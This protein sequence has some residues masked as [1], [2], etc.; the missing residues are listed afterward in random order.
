[1][2]RCVITENTSLRTTR[3]LPCKGGGGV[4][5]SQ[6]TLA[7]DCIISNNVAMGAG[8]GLAA[9]GGIV[10]R[11][12]ITDNDSGVAGQTTT[13]DGGGCF[14]GST[15]DCRVL[16]D[17]CQILCNRANTSHGGG[18]IMGSTS[19]LELR[20]C[21]V[22]GNTALANAGGIYAHQG[23]LELDNCTITD[24]HVEDSTS[25][26]AAGGFYSGYTNH[27]RN[28][29][30][31]GNTIAGSSV[32]SNLYLNSSATI[33]T[34]TNCCVAPLQTGAKV[35]NEGSFADDPHLTVNYQLLPDSLCINAGVYLEAWMDDA[36]DI[37]GHNRLDRFSLIPDI[38][39][40]EYMPS[41]SM[42][43]LR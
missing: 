37:A 7:E 34:F 16:L 17:T 30:I 1:M 20:N 29:I 26:T 18:I 31:Y 3:A 12:L 43:R 32:R 19:V 10:R 41:G 38:G 25:T 14:I 33:S 40:F 24:N 39:C 21:L 2:R 13:G 5:V 8:G 42:F 23:I 28:T 9:C 36:K 22:A 11:C 4:L 15:P 27:C 35:I 6:G